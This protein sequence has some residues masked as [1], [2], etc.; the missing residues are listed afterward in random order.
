MDKST[1]I[2]SLSFNK[3][4]PSSISPPNPMAAVG[5]APPNPVNTTIDSSRPTHMTPPQGQQAPSQGPSQGPP[6]QGQQRPTTSQNF[7]KPIKPVVIKK[8][9]FG[10]KESDY[11]STMVVFALILIF[12]SNFFFEILRKY[13]PNVMVDGK[14]TLIGS[15]IGA[16]IGSIVY[17]IV[18]AASK[19]D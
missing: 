15:L 16:L 2:K 9:Y 18:K 4:P 8:E 6:P 10:L 17:I 14:T 1:D 11:K 13:L 5:Q 19:L 3:K 12:N 7:S